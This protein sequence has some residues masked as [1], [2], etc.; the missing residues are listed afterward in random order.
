M[1]KLSLPTWLQIIYC[2]C[3]AV[4]IL[5]MNL[6]TAYYPSSFS[7]ICSDIGIVMHLLCAFNPI[8]IIC[9]IWQIKKY[10][11]AVN[12]DEVPRKY[13]FAWVIIGPILTFLGWGLS[14]SSFVLHSGG[15]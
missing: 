2:V 14:I 4:V 7:I 12:N 6:Y 13:Q 9:G 1:K 11:T 5:C 15:V 3:C 8:G 10:V